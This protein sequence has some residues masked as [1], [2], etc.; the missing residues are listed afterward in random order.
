MRDDTYSKSA[1][2]LVEL[3]A[4]LESKVATKVTFH[5]KQPFVLTEV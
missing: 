5:A 1:I 2:I 3:F 4:S